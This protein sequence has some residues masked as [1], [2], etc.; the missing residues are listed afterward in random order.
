MP[1]ALTDKQVRQ[2]SV[3]RIGVGNDEDRHDGVARYLTVPDAVYAGESKRLIT[4]RMTPAVTATTNVSI[5]GFTPD[6]RPARQPLR[7]RRD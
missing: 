5:V 7:S 2:R 1:S 6:V 3:T 4:A